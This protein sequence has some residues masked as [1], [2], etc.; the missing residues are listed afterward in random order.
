MP[1][2]ALSDGQPSLLRR[3]SR[4]PKG[5]RAMGRAVR[6]PAE[7]AFTQS[8]PQAPS[9]QQVIASGLAVLSP[10]SAWQGATGASTTASGMAI[11]TRGARPPV[12]MASTSSRWARARDSGISGFYN[13]ARRLA[14]AAAATGPSPPVRTGPGYPSQWMSLR[15]GTLGASATPNGTPWT[16]AKNG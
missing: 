4:V 12:T 1:G 16:N 14:R 10:T 11:A 5:R 2:P 9:S 13:V 8:Q 15:Y 7:P 6:K 3:E